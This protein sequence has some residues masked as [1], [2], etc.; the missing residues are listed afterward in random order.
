[1]PPETLF[2]LSHDEIDSVAG[3]PPDEW[4]TAGQAEINWD[5][6]VERRGFT[7]DLPDSRVLQPTSRA[8]VTVESMVL[9]KVLFSNFAPLLHPLFRRTVSSLWNDLDSFKLGRVILHI[10]KGW[11]ISPVHLC[12]HEEGG[13]FL[14]GGN[15]RYEVLKRS[16]SPYF[17]FLAEPGD[18]VKIE[19]L[20]SVQWIDC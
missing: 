12:V 4:P 18:V 7:I 3:L 1:M 14:G 6:S 10:A 17:Y 13:F 15:H 8:D 16:G 19:T 20:L 2:R 9:G 11:P 5:L